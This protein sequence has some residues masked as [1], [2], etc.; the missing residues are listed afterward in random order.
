M[1]WD[2]GCYAGIARQSETSLMQ[3][4]LLVIP[5][6]PTKLLSVCFSV[7]IFINALVQFLLHR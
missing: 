5:K 2:T 3:I 6:L 4:M 7:L 1:F